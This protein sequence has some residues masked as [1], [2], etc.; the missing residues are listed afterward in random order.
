MLSAFIDY[1]INLHNFYIVSFVLFLI[2]IF[3]SKL[4]IVVLMDPIFF[5]LR[6]NNLEAGFDIY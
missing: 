1:F 2:N 6:T 4:A 5:Y 3:I